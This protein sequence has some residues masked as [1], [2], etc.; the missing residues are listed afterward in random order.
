MGS[1]AAWPQENRRRGSM[2]R[3]REAPPRR[4]RSV[5]VPISFGAGRSR[6]LLALVVAGGRC[7]ISRSLLRASRPAHTPRL[8]PRLL[9]LPHLAGPRL[10][11][12]TGAQHT[13]RRG[14]RLSRGVLCVMTPQRSP[15]A[16]ADAL[17]QTHNGAEATSTSELADTWCVAGSR[18]SRMSTLGVAP[19]VVDAHA[20]RSR[21]CD[22]G[23]CTGIGRTR[24]ARCVLL[25]PLRAAR[26]RRNSKGPPPRL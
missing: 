26:H 18:K 1:G 10:H 20:C 23:A 22:R 2:K 11:W 7:S 8:Q 14:S 13:A 9:Q 24:A 16:L 19:L 25:A 15:R 4:R 12:S 6:C 3:A 17:S 5:R 21:V